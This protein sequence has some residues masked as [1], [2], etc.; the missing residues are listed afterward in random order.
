MVL[1]SGCG[2]SGGTTASTTSDID[3]PVYQKLFCNSTTTLCWNETACKA[4][5]GDFCA[6]HIDGDILKGYKYPAAAFVGTC[7]DPLDFPKSKCACDYGVPADEEYCQNDDDPTGD[8]TT[9]DPT[10][11]V[12]TDWLCTIHSQTK[13]VE[14]NYTTDPFPTNMK[15]CWVDPNQPDN[16]Q[17]CVFAEDLEGARTACKAEC[18]KVLTDVNAN[19]VTY[20]MFNDPDLEILSPPIDCTFDDVPLG[21]EPMPLG[22]GYQCAPEYNALVAWGGSTVLKSM[23]ATVAL[24]TSTGGSTGYGNTIGYIGYSVSGCAGGTCVVTI[25]AL[26]TIK[27]D[28]P[29]IFTD[30]AGAQTTYLLQ[31]VD[32]HLFQK[33]QGTL[34]QSRGT[35][36]FPTEP[37]VGG[38][39]VSDA[40]VA[41]ASLGPW[42]TTQVLTQATGS[43]SSA[44]ALTLNLT[45][46]VS[47]GVFTMAITSN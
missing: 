30:A 35:V 38:I 4:P 2:D 34:Y 44:G 39:S 10:G 9:G 41:G 18:D 12:A 22:G 8:P 43:I 32:L 36:V 46:N 5:P 23:R 14:H 20:N 3:P 21:D 47:G 7:T 37:F 16:V 15:E 13:C 11:G 25:D 19:I 6:A 33:V 29:G 27:S 40:I 26:E 45:L 24:A 1:L 17:Q 28:V 31:D 42:E